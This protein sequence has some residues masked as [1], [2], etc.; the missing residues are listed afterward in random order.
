MQF[1]GAAVTV[2]FMFTTW[3]ALR[4]EA[5]ESAVGRPAPSNW[6]CEVGK[7]NLSPLKD[8]QPTPEVILSR[9]WIYWKVN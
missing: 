8:G 2:K 9:N 7:G 4:V 3:A 1:K 6:W 5:D